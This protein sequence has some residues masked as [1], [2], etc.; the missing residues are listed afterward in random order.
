M[1]SISKKSRKIAAEK[2]PMPVA[3]KL[4]IKVKKYHKDNLDEAHFAEQRNFLYRKQ[5]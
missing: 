3:V 5:R 4:D 2:E 1:K